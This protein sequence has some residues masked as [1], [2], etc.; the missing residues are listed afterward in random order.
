[1]SYED[2]V[3][4]Q[5]EGAANAQARGE[6]PVDGEVDAAF[7]FREIKKSLKKN[8][9]VGRRKGAGEYTLKR[10]KNP[11]HLPG[12]KSVTSNLKKKGFT[13]D[14]TPRKR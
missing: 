5:M 3:R 2:N 9:G 11:V 6:C 13:A 8:Y 1:M 14:Y 10:G 7:G 12:L 4:R